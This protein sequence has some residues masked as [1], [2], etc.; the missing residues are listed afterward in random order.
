[1]KNKYNVIDLFAGAGGLSHG[2]YKNSKFKILAANEIEKDMAATYQLNHPNVKVYNKDIKDFSFKDLKEDLNINKKDVD[3]IIGGPPCQAF[4][5]VGKRLLEDPRGKLFQEFFRLV[6]EIE[7]KI[8]LFENVKGLISMDK[9]NLLKHII[10]LFESIGYFV[11]Y[12]IL[13]SLNYGVPQSRERVIIVGTH[14]KGIFKFPETTHCNNTTTKENFL[15]L[16]D[17]I[18]DLPSLGNNDEANEY[19][20]EPQNDFQKKMRENTDKLTDHS[21]PK[22]GIKLINLMKALP[23]GGS[24]EDLP[25][26]LR[27]KS[28]FKNTYCRLW[29]EQPSTTITRNFGTPSS[30]RCIHPRDPRPLSTREGARIQTFPD[31]YRFVGSKTSKNLQIGNAVPP[32]LS[33]HLA[34][35]ILE[36]FE[37]IKTTM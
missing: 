14:Q 17:A 3:V 11:E 5:T 18:S 31:T 28:G 23:D 27:P 34:K 32:K 24:P 25:L 9:G 33:E 20:I 30:S 7:P 1:L 26:D 15:T 36:F 2:F 37:S 29:W 4:S 10:S 19:F 12:K 21:S 8:F 6:Q 35:S 13:N 16:K 22:N